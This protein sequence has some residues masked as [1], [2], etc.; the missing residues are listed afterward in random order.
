M[1]WINKITLNNTKKDRLVCKNKSWDF[2][3]KCKTQAEFNNYGFFKL[4]KY[5]YFHDD[6]AL[7]LVS[8]ED[9]LTNLHT[10]YLTQMAD[11]HDQISVFYIKLVKAEI[12]GTYEASNPKWNNV[13]RL[14][15][16]KKVPAIN[17]CISR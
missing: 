10:I 5:Y 1:L 9:N 13:G 7:L 17:G 3:T 2:D 16:N 11:L 12:L 8:T 6:A 14:A 4:K 15:I